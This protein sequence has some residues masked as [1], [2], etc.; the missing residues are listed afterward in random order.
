MN[1]TD[2]VAQPLPVRG[3]RW[4]STAW[5]G[6]AFLILTEGS[7]FAYLFFSYFY[8]ASQSTGRW[9]PSGP[10][11]LMNASIN[12]L[13]LLSSSGVAWWGERGIA[14]DKPRQLSIGLAL[15]LGLGIIFMTIQGHEWATRPFILSSNSYSSLY[16]VITGFHGAHVLVGL[17]MLCA[18]LVWNLM[19][20]FAAGWHLEVSVGILYWHF[21]DLVWLAVYA[22]LYMSP[23]LS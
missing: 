9:P 20:R 10:P 8:L 19:G 2:F 7:L 5:W 6:M 4:Q 18:L 23:R 15:A 1:S 14:R 17:L 12:T 11:D 13:L 21:V 16:F 22:T 3:T